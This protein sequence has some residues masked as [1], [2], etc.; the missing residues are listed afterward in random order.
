MGREISRVIVQYLPEFESWKFGDLGSF[1]RTKEGEIKYIM[2][3]TAINIEGF[4]ETPAFW[5]L[6]DWAGLHIP[7]TKPK[8]SEHVK[9]PFYAV[10]CSFEKGIYLDIRKAFYQIGK[11]V[12][13][14]CMVKDG[15]LTAL[16]SFDFE[17]GLYENNKLARAMIMSLT[18][19]FS[20]KQKWDGKAVTVFEYRNRFF[21]PSLQYAIKATLQSVAQ[22]CRNYIAYWHTD[23]LIVPEFNLNYVTDILDT[24]RLPYAIKATGQT[25]IKGCG[26]YIVGSHV[27]YGR[28]KGAI[29][30]LVKLPM[31]K[32]SYLSI[33]DYTN[34]ME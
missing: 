9:I 25:R 19:E 27:G 20:V 13:L 32:A 17:T 8:N 18:G 30:N 28:G 6:K 15:V 33:P 31:W 24:W 12:G 4:T 5:V 29:S 3:A 23:G 26:N 34:E 14:E 10:P 1:S 11:K 21:A 2:E 22:E 16:G 7:K